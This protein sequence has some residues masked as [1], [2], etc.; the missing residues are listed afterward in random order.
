MN[1]YEQSFDVHIKNKDY[2]KYTKTLSSIIIVQLTSLT[3][4]LVCFTLPFEL[5]LFLQAG[6]EILYYSR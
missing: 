5:I 6:H 4:H 3:L 2:Q 1:L